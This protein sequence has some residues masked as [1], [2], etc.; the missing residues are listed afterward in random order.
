VLFASYALFVAIAAL[1]LLANPEQWGRYTNLRRS[2]TGVVAIA[3]GGVAILLLT[4]G[5]GD[6]HTTEGQV[7]AWLALAWTAPALRVTGWIFLVVP[8]LVPSTLSLALPVLA[9]LSL[10]ISPVSSGDSKNQP[11]KPASESN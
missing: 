2:F 1:A 5:A 11:L 8:A 7:A 3:A 10:T 4:G 9:L 6:T